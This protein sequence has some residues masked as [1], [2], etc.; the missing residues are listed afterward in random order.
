ML[1]T[2]RFSSY[3]LQIKPS[4][5]V[6]WLVFTLCYVFL[7]RLLTVA[8]LGKYRLGAVILALSLF[9][10]LSY[11][12][13]VKNAA[14]LAMVA[15]L[16]GVTAVSAWVNHVPLGQFASFVRIPIVAYL[17]YH[18]VQRFLN[19]KARVEKV[20]RLLYVIA[21]FQLPVIALQRLAYPWLPDRLKFGTLAGQLSAADFGM[22]SFT[23]DASM[24]F[25]LVLLVILLLFDRRVQSIVR[26][27]WPL[28][29][30]LT[31]TVL[32]TNSEIQ[33]T[34]ILLIWGIY[35]LTHLRLKTLVIIGVSV[36]LLASLLGVLFQAGVMTFAPLQ[37]TIGRASKLVGI[38]EGEVR[39]ETFFAGGHA[40][41]AAIYYYLSEPIKWIGDG[42]GTA[43]NTATRERTVGSWGHVF[44]FYAEVGL[45]G[46]MLSILIFFV[47][48]FPIR[49]GRSTVRMRTSWVRALAFLS[50]VILAFAKYPMGD[51]PMMFTYC[52]IL[53]GHQVLL[54][55]PP[56]APLERQAMHVAA[57]SSRNFEN[58]RGH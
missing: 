50:V 41:E 57:S 6:F 55:S 29:V 23:G 34:T 39:E 10:V 8:T 13:L 22:G 51:S 43:Y 31:L 12:K 9:S 36:A 42:P 11:G 47:I 49:I 5:L 14:L 4:A 30:W 53:I 18:L 40:R 24:S 37:H 16:C 1:G 25:L 46:L 58:A 2:R 44:T 32:F 19:N 35:L 17:V 28:A 38:F 7:S 27:R 54:D 3:R 20:L 52:V 26:G 45:F 48:A 15:A 21:A 33:H 56:D